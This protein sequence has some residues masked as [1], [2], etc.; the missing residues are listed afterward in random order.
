MGRLLEI[1]CDASIKTFGKRSFACAGA[2][3]IEYDKSV[4]EIM[5]DI[6]NN[7][8]EIAAILLGVKLAGEL[9]KQHEDIE[10]IYI[11]SDSK[12]SVKGINE[13]IDVWIRRR[14]ADGIM[15]NYEGNPVKHQDVYLEVISYIIDNNLKIHVRHQK[16]HVK[17]TSESSM[18]KASDRF[19][20]SNG[21]YIDKN[22]LSRISIYNNLIDEKTRNKLKQVRPLA[23]PHEKECTYK[24][25]CK[26]VIPKN[27]KE[28]IL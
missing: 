14:G 1:C 10:E 3:A 9:V 27:Y 16:G 25:M 24:Q 15:Y 2:I 21:Y 26:F 7:R 22:T 28:Y 4:E 18:K 12:F 11:Y 17:V 6:T 5:P 13:W 19:F 8:A 23:Y 20:D